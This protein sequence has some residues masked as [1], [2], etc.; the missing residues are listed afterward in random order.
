MDDDHDD[1]RR[2]PGTTA[3]LAPSNPTTR[4]PE[5]ADPPS[6]SP[7]VLEWVQVS[8]PS[9]RSN[10]ANVQQIRSHVTRRRHQRVASER[11]KYGTLR[12][13]N[14]SRRILPLAIGGDGS[15][16]SIDEKKEPEEE[17]PLRACADLENIEPRSHGKEWAKKEIE[18]HELVSAPTVGFGSRG[19]QA[20]WLLPSNLQAPPYA[21]TLI[22]HLF[23]GVA[24]KMFNMNDWPNK[25]RST[26]WTLGTSSPA[27]FHMTLCTAATHIARLQNQE[28]SLQS[29]KLKAQALAGVNQHLRN[30]DTALSDETIGAILS[31]L[32][33]EHLFGDLR[34]WELHMAG[35]QR[36]VKL[37]GGFW[38]LSPK[39]QALIC[40]IDTNVSCVL[41]SLPRFPPPENTIPVF[42]LPVRDV[43]LEPLRRRGVRNDLLA[44]MLVYQD[45]TAQI[46]AA[47]G[48]CRFLESNW[49]TPAYLGVSSLGGRQ[50]MN[51]VLRRLLRRA[52]TEYDAD[53]WH[54]I[55]TETCRLA[56]LIHFCAMYEEYQRWPPIR[57]P[58]NAISLK[59]AVLKAELLHLN[60]L[61]EFRIWVLFTGANACIESSLEQDWFDQQVHIIQKLYLW[62][63]IEP[64]LKKWFWTGDDCRR[65]YFAVWQRVGLRT[66]VGI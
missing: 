62:E 64:I 34:I 27:A 25:Y 19:S 43:D 1:H 12:Q 23:E 58:Q 38:S 54:P 7:A 60:D 55:L 50:K 36:I 18:H 31:L 32:V 22:N 8:T 52:A 13:T 40:W 46:A 61:E 41:D 4:I 9:G 39:L 66:C 6:L 33:Q 48:L 29:V 26:L 35:L 47:G 3:R 42:D 5:H 24:R 16:V 37:R 57:N 21:A 10:V 49:L 20:I 2:A 56:V 17:L 11:T 51:V 53:L 30:P 28:Y 65:R 45:L 14:S 63:E 59:D 15:R 44:T